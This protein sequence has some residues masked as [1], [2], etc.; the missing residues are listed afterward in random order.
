[1]E[2]Y[3]ASSLFLEKTMENYIIIRWITVKDILILFIWW[4]IWFLP[5]ALTK[6]QIASYATESSDYFYFEYKN[7]FWQKSYTK[8]EIIGEKYESKISKEDFNK[9]EH[10]LIRRTIP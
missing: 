2:N 9:L 4:I 3:I 10:S 7:F 6:K 8:R 5:H 1:M